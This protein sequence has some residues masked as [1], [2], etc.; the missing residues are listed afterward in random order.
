MA[1]GVL[2]T[3]WIGV[4]ERYKI[5]TCETLEAAQILLVSMLQQYSEMNQ[6]AKLRIFIDP[7]FEGCSRSGV[8]MFNLSGQI[9]REFQCFAFENN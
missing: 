1:V 9:E 4:F 2:L 3:Y 7:D 5:Y 8:R 6:I